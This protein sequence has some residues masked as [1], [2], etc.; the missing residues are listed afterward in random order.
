MGYTIIGG[1]LGPAIDLTIEGRL[2]VSLEQFR[3]NV[4]SAGRL[5]LPL[6]P[7]ATKPSG[8]RLAVVGGG[9]SINQP[10]IIAGLKALDRAI[11]DIWAING[12]WGWCEKQGIDATFFAIDPHEIVATW[13]KGATK[14]VLATCCHPDAFAGMKGAEIRVIDMTGIVSG[15]STATAVPHIAATMGY[16]EVAF[17]GCESSYQPGRTHAYGTE[18]RQDQVIVCVDGVDH[19]TALDYFMQAHELAT[20]IHGLPG[21]LSEESGGLLRALVK[22]K[23]LP[24][25][26]EAHWFV[27]WISSSCTLERNEAS[28][29][30]LD[31][32]GA[33]DKFLHASLSDHADW[34]GG[35]ARAAE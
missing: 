7:R 27:K 31:P 12:A 28:N 21:Y 29:M 16:E 32:V 22:G 26:F 18:D 8:R 9:P 23:A 34:D 30:E 10:Q 4:E 1:T 5:S 24:G 3:A 11:W 15:S 13:C 19:L 2:P 20:M 25:P 17:L 35:T 6:L 33:I 14:A